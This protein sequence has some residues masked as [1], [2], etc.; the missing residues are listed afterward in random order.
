MQKFLPERYP[1]LRL[2]LGIAACGRRAAGVIHHGFMIGAFLTTLFFSLS[3]IFAQKSLKAVGYMRA[4]IGRLLFAMLVLG[5]ISHLFGKGMGG[6]GR[7]WLLLSGVVGMGI[8]DLVY[9]SALPRLGSRLTVLMAQCLAAP[10]GAVAEGLWLGTRVTLTQMLWG[11]VILAGVALA[12]MPSRR[13]PPRVTIK[14]LGFVFGLAAAAG[15][16]LGA[17]LSR[18]A[19]MIASAQGET[20]DGFTAAYQ[21]I[22]GGLFVALAYF[23]IVALVEKRSSAKKHAIIPEQKRTWRSYIWIVCHGGSGAVLGVTCYQWALF[24]TPSAIVLPI[25][26]CTPLVIVPMTYW[27][28]GERPTRRSLIGGLVAVI[29]A[30]ALAIAR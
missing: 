10:I 24:T 2:A 11:T 25:V 28:E 21:R 27:I 22:A 6:A 29:G 4:N 17:V 13:N 30:I 26:A 1:K 12:L 15:Q 16:G 14:P 23:A 3:T 9:L 18:K 7:N 8:G 20:I 19:N 5:C